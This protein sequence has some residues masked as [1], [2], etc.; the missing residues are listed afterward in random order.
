M[1]NLFMKSLLAITIA[2]SLIACSK[3]EETTP[4]PSPT[5]LGKWN[6][7]NTI[8][9]AKLGTTVLL[10]DTT[11][12]TTGQY[13]IEFTANKAISTMGTDKDTADYVYANNRLM[14]ISYDPTDGYDTTT[15]NSVNLTST[16]L[17]ATTLDTTDTGGGILIISSYEINMKK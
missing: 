1:K 6:V 13:T 16:S 15:F 4:T 17:K 5:L 14:V 8:S 10:D 7:I 11:S 2:S 12:F 9:M 3:D